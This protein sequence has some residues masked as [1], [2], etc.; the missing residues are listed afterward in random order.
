M[1]RFLLFSL[2]L[3][4]A[5]NAEKTCEEFWLRHDYT[6]IAPGALSDRIARFAVVSE[7]QARL[8]ARARSYMV[9]NRDRVDAW[10]GDLDGLVRYREP[11][12]GAYAFVELAFPCDHD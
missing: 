5:I 2:I 3:W 9:P 8:Q 4:L 6:T 1:L 12:A 10:A 7:N 11:Q